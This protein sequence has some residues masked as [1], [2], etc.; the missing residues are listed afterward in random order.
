MTFRVA[1]A[2]LAV[3]LTTVAGAQRPASPT[4][5]AAMTLV[6]LAELPRLLDP[7]LSPD[8]ETV[9]Y[10]LSN[11]DWTL[12]RAVWH[13][14]RQD[15]HGGRPRALTSGGAGDVPGSARWSPDGK[16]ILFMRAGQMMLMPASGGEPAPLPTHATSVSRASWSPDGRQIYFLAADPPTPDEDARARARDDAYRVD[17][18]FTQQHLWRMS[19]DGGADTKLTTGDLSTLSYHVS[20]DG[21]TIVLQRAPTPQ[22]DDWPKGEVWVMDA[23][24][25]HARAVTHNAIEEKGPELSPD[26]SQILFLA[27]VNAR[28]DFFYNTN[29]FVVPVAGGAPRALLP[30]FEYGVDQASWAP[31]GRSI[32]ATVNMGVRSEIFQID[33]VTG[34]TRRL[35]H[36]DHFIPPTWSVVPAAGKMVFQ[37]DEPSRYGDAYTLDIPRDGTSEPGTPARVTGVFDTF[38]EDFAVPRQEKVDWTG[39]DGTPLEGILFYPIGYVPGTRYPMV[40]QLHG[41]P[42]ESDKFG[43]G[44]QLVVNYV[45]TLAAR[46]YFVFRPN[47]RGSSGYG[48]T[49]YRDVVGHYF[50]HMQGDVL[51][52][53]DALVARG[54][55]DPDR[56]VLAGWSAGGHLANKLITI[57]DRF[58]AAS[59]GAGVSDWVSMYAQT[60]IRASRSVWFGGTPWQAGAPFSAFWDHSPIK[61]VSRVKTPTIFFAG[62]Q[63]ARIPASQ[64]VEMYRGVKSLGVPTHL[65]IAPREGHQWSEL[66]HQ[67]FKAN[68]ELA[69]FERWARGRSYTAEVAPAGGTPGR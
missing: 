11:A 65:Y 47:Y 54:M 37:F 15:T 25:G 29:L 63:D 16:T 2:A 64:L 20:R 18:T 3:G 30:D 56:L 49:F 14:W 60:D 10:M 45:P 13:L 61:D 6:N 52:G 34:K 32:L 22:I 48:N 33:A 23:N 55:A 66:R 21:S 39:A 35:T 44:S 62:E 24:G 67:I 42:M 4:P 19:P 38:T 7:Q 28:L 57:T 40:V 36:G 58:K 53:V 31:D 68:T 46:G 12:N 69:W 27:D 5:P 59:V 9:I 1:T 50:N 17:E 43:I 51:A 8:G 41:G 26:K